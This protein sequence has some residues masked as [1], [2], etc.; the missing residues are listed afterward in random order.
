[1]ISHTVHFGVCDWEY[2]FAVRVNHAIFLAF[3][4]LRLTIYEITE[5]IAAVIIEGNTTMP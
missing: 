3:A 5:I 2:Y 4:H 1:M